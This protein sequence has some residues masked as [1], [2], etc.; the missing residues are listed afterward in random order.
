MIHRI[1]LMADDRGGITH[2]HIEGEEMPV[3][4]GAWAFYAPLV[5]LKL[6]HAR[7]GRQTCLHRRAR[8]FV[9]PGPAQ[10]VLNRVSAMTGRRIGP[11]LV[12]DWHRALSTR[13]TRRTAET[14]IAARRLAQA[15]LGPGVGDPVVVQ[16]LSA[17]YLA[18]SSVTAGFVQ[19]NA[20]TLPP[21]PSPDAGALR[22][23][24]VRPDRIESC[25]RQPING[26][27]TDLNSV[28]GVVPLDAEEEV[29]DLAARLD[30]AL[31]GGDVTASVGRNDV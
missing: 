5:K 8:R 26:Y 22:A 18:A 4:S 27:V 29:A 7:E 10:R 20:L 11:Y 28:V 30:A 25:I 16:H 13:A 2:A 21:G 17:P 15:G 1:E 14:W 12:E 23:A 6:S 19:E 9:S 24:G 31:D 3:Q